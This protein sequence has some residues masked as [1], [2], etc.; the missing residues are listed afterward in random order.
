M[1]T[2]LKVFTGRNSL[3]I[4]CHIQELLQ[5]FV[6]NFVK[7][8]KLQEKVMLL[9]TDLEEAVFHEIEQNSETSLILKEQQ[10]YPCHFQH[11]QAVYRTNIRRH[12]AFNRLS[13]F[14]I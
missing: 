10:L 14:F 7:K 3:I 11:F 8:D 9:R 5:K 4:K 13:M 2:G 1:L 6:Y 12:Y